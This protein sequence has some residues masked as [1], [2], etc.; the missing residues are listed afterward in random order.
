MNTVEK[1]IEHL[2]GYNCG[3]CGYKSCEEFAIALI[4]GRVEL[5]HCSVLQQNK[6]VN[7]KLAI[8][9]CL[10]KKVKSEEC[11]S[12]VIDRYEAD[13]LLNPLKGEASCREVLLP[14][15]DEKLC[16]GDI[17]KYRPLGCPIVHYAK[18]ICTNHKLITVNIIGPC[19]RIV[20]GFESKDIGCCMV[21]GFEGE[22]RGKSVNVGE[23]V[24]FLPNHCMMQK[25]HSGVVVNIESNNII[26]EGIDLKVWGLPV[27]ING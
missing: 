2:P 7:N 21:I 19:K 20:N 24:R 25:V 8:G 11:L 18:I 6:F 9:T 5:N 10:N 27:Q 13:I 1:I 15:I 23:T 3:T 14:F 17:V 16:E 12:G 26:I 22:Y 4:N